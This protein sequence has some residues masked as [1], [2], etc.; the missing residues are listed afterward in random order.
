M[1]S[2]L[3]KHA[4]EK[5]N[6]LKQRHNLRIFLFSK[7][8]ECAIKHKEGQKESPASS[9]SFQEDSKTSVPKPTKGVAREEGCQ[10]TLLK[11]TYGK[12]YADIYKSDPELT[13][14][15]SRS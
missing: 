1:C 14:R 4:L 7:R 10:E 8:K 13:K 6:G 3:L 5:K 9:R 2:M 12:A 11:R 15:D